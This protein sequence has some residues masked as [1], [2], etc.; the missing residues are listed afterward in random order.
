VHDFSKLNTF[1]IEFKFVS[2]VQYLETNDLKRMRMKMPGYMCKLMLKG[3]ASAKIIFVAFSN[4]CV[5]FVQENC[6]RMYIY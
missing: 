2:R 4:L 1:A 3:I 5:N 6:I